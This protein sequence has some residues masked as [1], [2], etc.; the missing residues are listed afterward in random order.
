MKGKVLFALMIVG[1]LLFA[2]IALCVNYANYGDVTTQVLLDDGLTCTINGKEVK[3][4]DTVTVGLEYAKLKVC[5]SS[6]TAALIACSGNWKSDSD[7]VTYDDGTSDTT[8]HAEFTID[9]GKAVHFD[10]WIFID[11][12]NSEMDHDA[13]DLYLDYDDGI[14]VKLIGNGYLS[15]DTLIYKEDIDLE[16]TANDGQEHDFHWYGS[17][18]NHYDVVEHKINDTGHWSVGTI[19]L[20]CDNYMATAHGKLTI[21]VD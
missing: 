21:D 19:H 16:I 1:I 6:D 17:Y 9:F 15:G 2:G 18:K 7:R 4:G 20:V 12:C 5:V 8:K 13:I 11:N 3:D 10:G 14:T